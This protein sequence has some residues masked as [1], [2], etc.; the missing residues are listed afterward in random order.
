MLSLLSEATWNESKGFN[1]SRTIL[2]LLYSSLIALLK[3]QS[4]LSNALKA[5]GILPIELGQGILLIC[6]RQMGRLVPKLTS[7]EL[8]TWDHP[9]LHFRITFQLPHR[10]QNPA[11]SWG[12]NLIWKS[13]VASLKHNSRVHKTGRPFG[14][15]TCEVLPWKIQ[16]KSKGISNYSMRK[17]EFRQHPELVI[18]SVSQQ[19]LGT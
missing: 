6:P 8:Q 18:C 17:Q 3:P 16:R 9:T 5:Q 11:E 12:Q 2:S 15:I 4:I 19:N 14:S 1:L 13:S 7:A 10:W